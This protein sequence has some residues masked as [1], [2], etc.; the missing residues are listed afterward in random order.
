MGTNLK[1]VL[2]CPRRHVQTVTV[3]ARATWS[4]TIPPSTPTW[5]AT[6]SSR[7]RWRASL[8][9]QLAGHANHPRRRGRL[10]RPLS[11]P[12][13]PRLQLVL[14][15]W[16]VDHRPAEQ[17]LLQP[18]SL[19]L[20]SVHRG[21]QRRAAGRVRRQDQ[22]GHRGHH[23]LRSGCHQ[24][25]R[26]H[27]HLLSAPSARQQAASISPTAARTG[28]TFIEVD[29]LNTGRFLDPPEF[30]VFHDKGNEAERLRP[31]G[32]QLYPGRLDPPGP[33]LQPLLVSDAELL[34]QPEC[35][36]RRQRTAPAPAPPSATWATPT[37]APRSAPQYLADLYAR[38]QQRLVFNLG[39]FVRRDDYNYYPSGN[40]LADLGPSN[41]QT[42]SIAQYRTLHQH[43]GP[44]G[45]LLRQ[46]NQQPSRS[47]RSTVRPSCARTTAWAWSN[48]P[49]T[50]PASTSTAT[51]CPATPAP[52]QCDAVGDLS[53][54]NPNYLRRP[55]A[56]TT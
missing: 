36:E 11:R 4:K 48:Q 24:A 18:A 52:S 1:L 25:H 51:R 47:A 45:L 22:P 12:R 50:R 31:R 20:H 42:S 30:T 23:A 19:Q 27:L 38:H 49:I 3:E 46:G 54:A 6:C 53:N 21:H 14:R 32:L 2:Q 41:L 33:Q 10:Q 26:Q 34:R 29:G 28:A 16:P 39:A 15:R 5:T 35:A 7:C 44:L 43:R 13:R 17:G 55:C 40:P 9:A 37:S 56:L 8:P